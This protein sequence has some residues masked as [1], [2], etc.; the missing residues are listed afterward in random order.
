[1][2]NRKRIKLRNPFK[3]L[4]K[5]EWALWIF[6]LA[7]VATSFFAVQN[8]NYATLAVSLLGVTSLIFAAKGDAFGLILM[9]AFSLIYAFVSYGFGYYGE[10]CIYLAMQIPVCLTSLISWIKNPSKKE[11]ETKIGKLAPKY[12]AVMCVL[13]VA[14]TTA[15]YFI[16]RAFNTENL[17]F[18]TIS[19]ATSFAALYLM[20]FR[21]PAYAAVFILNDVVLI[22]LWSLACAS[23]L[24]YVPMVVCF[25]IFLINDI[26]SFYSWTKRRKA[27]AEA[28]ETAD[29]AQNNET[30][31]D[32]PQNGDE[33]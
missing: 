16:L 17:I 6:S 10:M 19:V 11:G 5:F 3:N 13:T 7:A 21:V 32:N 14:V 24:N 20:A 27:Q 33:Q 23:S 18:S 26:Y 8:T 25:S 1:M 12:A 31:R 22:V 29:S 15:F 28:A 30:A 9:L 4:T 2:K